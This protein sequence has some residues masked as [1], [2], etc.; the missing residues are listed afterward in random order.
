M[1]DIS[2][3]QL[4]WFRDKCIDNTVII[5]IGVN[6]ELAALSSF[7]ANRS[8]SVCQGLVAALKR[9]NSLGLGG[10]SAGDWDAAAEWVVRA[11]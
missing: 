2:V 6:R 3:G 9:H 8:R 7:G 5:H 11:A 4:D 1:L 10:W